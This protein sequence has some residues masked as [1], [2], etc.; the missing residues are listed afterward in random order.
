MSIYNIIYKK[1]GKYSAIIYP[2]SYVS[3]F[4]E[5][6][7][8][9]E[10]LKKNLKCGDCVLFDLLLSNG[11]NFNR[12]AEFCYDGIGINKNLVNVITVPGKDL[13]ELNQYYKG[14]VKE[15]SKSVLA[16]NERFKFATCK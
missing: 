11:D 3:P 9:S 14:R 4:E 2:V 16:P 5:I 8:I 6:N 1:Y 10:D 12:F 15:L 7:Q 13:K